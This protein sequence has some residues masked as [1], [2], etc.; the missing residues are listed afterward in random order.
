M[1]AGIG[2][3]AQNIKGIREAGGSSPVY[4]YTYTAQEECTVTEPVY[5]SLVVPDKVVPQIQIADGL[6]M[7]EITD[8]QE[9]LPLLEQGEPTRRE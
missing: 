4:R 5:L 3:S 7:E 6:L 2:A 9:L 8:P 1:Q